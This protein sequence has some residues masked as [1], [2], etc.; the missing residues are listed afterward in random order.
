MAVVDLDQTYVVIAVLGSAVTLVGLWYISAK[1]RHRRQLVMASA[2]TH[3][4]PETVG[5]DSKEGVGTA[6]TRRESRQRLRGRKRSGG[7]GGGAGGGGGGAGG[8]GSLET[9]HGMAK[10]KCERSGEEFTFFFGR[11]SVLSQWHSC[12]FSVDGEWYNCAEQYMMHQK[13]GEV[14]DT[15]VRNN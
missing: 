3:P 8:G 6:D 10:K 2:T 4:P 13:A 12:Q 1:L 14:N 9:S 15:I 11:E 5:G 7:G